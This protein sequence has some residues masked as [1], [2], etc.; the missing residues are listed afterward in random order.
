VCPTH[1]APPPVPF[2]AETGTPF[3]VPPPP[4]A[5]YAVR[6]LLGQGGF[7]AAFQAE[8]LSDKVSV[9][10]KVARA[11]QFS[12]SHRLLQEAEALRAIGPP[13][14]PAV[15]DVGRLADG[16]AYMV[17]EFV[18]AP[19]LAAHMTDAAGSVTTECFARVAPALVDLVALAHHRGFL[20]CDLKPENI[21]VAVNPAEDGYVAKLFDFGLVRRLGARRAED[22]REEAPEGTPEYMSPE[23]C[24]GGATLDERSDIYSLGV[25][26]YE[27][28]VGAPPFWG[29]VAMVQQ[30]HR[31]RRPPLP[32]RR[33][34]MIATL[35]EVILRCL[36]KDPDRRFPSATDLATALRSALAGAANLSFFIFGTS[37]TGTKPPSDI[38][39]IGGAAEMKP[40]PGAVAVPGTAESPPGAAKA[41]AP[42]R[43][44]KAVALVFLDGI[45]NV[46]AVREVIVLV[47]GQL[48][49]AAGTQVVIAFGHEVGDNPTRAAAVAAQVFIDR[50]LCRQ[51]FVDLA[52]V[53]IQ[54]R[55]DGSRRYQSPL[56]AKKDQYPTDA[57]PPGVLLSRTASDMLP[58]LASQPV[59]GRA[60]VVVLRRAADAAELTTTRIG[61][62]ALIGRDDILHVLL[63]AARRATDITPGVSPLPTI[64]TLVGEPGTGKSHLTAVL[65]Q[66]LETIIPAVKVLAF[67][68]KEALGGAGD[69]TT[70]ELFRHILRVPAASPPDLG[71]AILAE[72]L[73]PELAREV[74]AGVAVTM[75]W[76]SP[77]HPD[78]RSLSAAPGALRSATARAAGEAL[79][80]VARQTPLALVLEDAHFA[81]ETALDALE[82]ATLEEAGCPLWVAVIGRP[83]F[84]RGRTAWS[85]RAAHHMR[86]DLPALDPASAA[87]LARRLL[88]PAENVPASAVTR[89]CER[90]QGIPLLL[91]ELVRGLKRDG[92]V[93]RSSK[94]GGWFLATDELDRLPDLPL[95][96]WLAGREIELLPPDLAAHA[97]LASML[98]AE[99]DASELEG[100]MQGLERDGIAPET[101]LD[102][103]VG[104]ARLTDS[105]LLVRHR[106]RRMGFRHA[107]LRETVYQTVPATERAAVHGAAY[108][109]YAANVALPDEQRLPQMALHAARCGLKNEAAELYLTLAER[110]KK[111]HAYLDA[112]SLYRDAIA[113]LGDESVGAPGAGVREVEARQG[114]GI[115]RFR[116][117]RHEDALKD[118]SVARLRAHEMELREREIEILLD[119]SLVL[120][121]MN[122]W[123]RSAKLVEEAQELA[124]QGGT[125]LIEA[126][127]V[128]AHGTILHRADKTDQA[129]AYFERGAIMAEA[130]GAD[131]YETNVL[132]LGLAGWGY[133]MLR[134]FDEAEAMFARLIALTEERGDVVNLTVVLTNRSILS[135]LSQKP[136]RMIADYKRL[137]LIAREY[138]LPLVECLA[139]KDLGEVHFFLGQIDE[140]EQQVRRAIGVNRQVLGPSAHAT[141]VADLLLGR[142]LVYR[143]D[144]V[145]ARDVMTEIRQKQQAAR[146]IGQ[147]E[148]EFSPGNQILADCVGLMVDG[149]GGPAWE[150]LLRRAREIM[151][152]PQDLIEVM[153]LRALATLRA[154]NVNAAVML[155]DATIDE[156]GRTAEI[157][158]GRLRRSRE[159]ASLEMSAADAAA[160]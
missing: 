127:L 143:G 61:A 6:S 99:F 83:A 46:A 91:V 116:L 118:L 26:L 72:R 10:I 134:R 12:A 122:D 44:R 25:I 100:V 89:L 5:G 29:N 135:L 43:E 90:T 57:D 147:T 20:H 112:E 34:P 77:D 133:S 79:R 2:R 33:T 119:E 1:G 82:Y 130:L 48:A 50:G 85:S 31:S 19:T 38:G 11:D 123:A 140:A 126:R 160:G 35:E 92:L 21:F 47:G 113:N 45:S 95:V 84:G 3:Q 55:P 137:I 128:Y 30:N 136:D 107:L 32:S 108:H 36:A 17:M 131:G 152:Q 53:S 106:H 98:G 111:R 101:E 145:G 156:A 142:V 75:G 104:L 41:A 24:E 27:M 117:G 56:F 88:A 87:E 153:E 151:L 68:A 71:R 144:I 9:A 124:G 13:A 42:V 59:L 121:W 4:L 37:R 157:V 149:A 58:D 129:C 159:V 66:H 120:D 109:Y 125:P 18:G 76:V 110:A 8:R 158:L 94:T 67:R 80:A 39:G 154:G 54:L 114:L 63:G 138:G 7:G 23:Q 73:G 81:D 62:P 28:A 69:Q 93:R 96:Q 102:A 78:V 60:G 105:G 141:I 16:A 15:Y 148:T 97:R 86:L 155:F 150:D 64:T 103:S 65:L 115:M 49:H 139:Q 22:T 40:M 14:V 70:R 51:V 146:A 132:S 74:W 52:S